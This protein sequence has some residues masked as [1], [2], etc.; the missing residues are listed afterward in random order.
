M[1]RLAPEQHDTLDDVPEP[2]ENPVLF[3]HRAA[4]SDLAAAYRAGRLPHALLFVGPRGIGKATAAY[5]LANHL[6]RHGDPAA[7]PAEIAAPDPAS[8]LF[9]QVASGAHPGVLHL[10]RPLN[11]E[12]KGFR[13]ALT[14]D[15]I[16]RINR[17]L[18]LTSHDGSY[19]IVI[20][21]PADDM[22][23]NAANA[24]LKNLEEP[25][26]RT[27]FMLI[28]NSPGALLP[29]IR[30]RCQVVRLAPLGAADLFEALGRAGFEAPAG[31]EARDALAE[32]SGGSVRRAI[33]LTQYGG[34]EIAEAVD[35]IA[36]AKAV[37]VPEAHKL[38]DAVGGRDRAV[39]F[40][41]FNEH[42]LSLLSGTAAGAARHGD[43]A[44]AAALSEAWREARL[45]IDEAT[46]YNLD[47]KQHALN[48]L[49]RLN[50][51]LR[52]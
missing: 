50:D 38:A 51:T 45:A 34:L 44:R 9:R 4:L 30:S 7:A 20:V 40:E 47:R 23:A 42:V 32:R 16:R 46:T 25:P 5:H 24:L 13:S 39:P 48:M 17:F 1:E 43:L 10:T 22:N 11:K 35:R 19:R 15:E 33:M 28:A 14:V 18:S 36:T 21:D 29:T 6:L 27:L 12:G 41:L 37:N 26:A 3:G 52:M 31:D 8:A 49:F 2:A